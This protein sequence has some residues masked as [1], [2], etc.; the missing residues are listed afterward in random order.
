MK[1]SGCTASKLGLAKVLA[2]EQKIAFPFLMNPG[3]PA[4]PVHT[5]QRQVHE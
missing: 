5:R 1:S 2:I 3:C 4:S